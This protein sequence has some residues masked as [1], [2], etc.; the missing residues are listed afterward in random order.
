[1]SG[2]DWHSADHSSEEYSFDGGR[3]QW[4][5][6]NG[7][8]KCYKDSGDL[9]GLGCK[10]HKVWICDKHN[11]E[12]SFCHVC[13]KLLYDLSI[14]NIDWPTCG[15][16]DSHGS[17]CHTR[18]NTEISGTMC[19]DGDNFWICDDHEYICQF[20]PECGKLLEKCATPGIHLKEYKPLPSCQW[21]DGNEKCY[22]TNV[23]GKSGTACPEHNTWI[24]DEHKDDHLHCAKCGK[25][26]MSIN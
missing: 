2:I 25:N 3:C 26:L 8:L 22:A 14:D 5:G 11:N 19:V 16:S 18:I 21:S 15:W 7:F 1:M 12:H 20:C 23:T 6:D 24:C 17:K 4:I 13:G 9:A 10:E